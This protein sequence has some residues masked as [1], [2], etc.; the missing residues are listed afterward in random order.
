MIMEEI[1]REISRFIC[2]KALISGFLDVFEEGSF[3]KDS[4]V[5]AL[6]STFR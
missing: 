2:G 6:I 3:L 1:F 5:F 4:G